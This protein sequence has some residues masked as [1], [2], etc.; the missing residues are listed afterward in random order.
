MKNYDILLFD[1]DGTLT[2]PGLGITNAV[3]YS[4]EK[5]GLPVPARQELYKMIGPPLTWSYQTYFGFSE[6]K[7]VEAVKYYREHYG[8]VGLLENEVYPGIGELLKALRAG[9][10]TLCV[11]TS[12]PE[13]YAGIILEHFGLAESFHYICG[14]SFD[15]KI[16]TKHEVIEY[17]L[18]RMGSPERSRVLMIGDREHDILGAKASGLGSLG[19]LYGYGD[20]AELEKAGAD[21]IVESVEE[22]GEVLLG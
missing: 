6:E 7:S 16:G 3:M 22:L 15:G 12:K 20:R 19:V 14:A 4:L 21:T 9:G 17:A 2:D 8:T 13:K 18:E 11:A 1:L 10:R 5:F